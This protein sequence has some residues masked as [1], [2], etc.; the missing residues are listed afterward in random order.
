MFMVFRS[1]FGSFFLCCMLMLLG[2][3]LGGKMEPKV[4]ANLQK[5][6]FKSKRLL[7]DIVLHFV[8]VIFASPDPSKSSKSHQRSFNNQEMR[9]SEKYIQQV[10]QI[11]SKS[12]PKR[13][14][15]Q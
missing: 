1:V 2:S 12:E 4:L 15:I 6:Y 11:A 10:S 7:L 14:K 9:D 8:F 5:S 13:D 3:T